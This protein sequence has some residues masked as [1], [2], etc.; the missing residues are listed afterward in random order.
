MSTH[1]IQNQMKSE[2]IM[3]RRQFGRVA[4][5]V[6]AVVGLAACGGGGG[7]NESEDNPLRAAYDQ[8]NRGMTKEQVLAI[9][10]REPETKS[11]GTWVYRSNSEYLNIGFSFQNGASVRTVNGA[12]WESVGNSPALS[13][14]K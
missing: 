7:G 14:E 10:G 8:I 9:V 6:L 2:S 11:D 4:V 5:G 12:R 1:P 3:H 13:I